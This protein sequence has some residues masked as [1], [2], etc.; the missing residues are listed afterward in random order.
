MI[1]TYEKAFAAMKLHKGDVIA[2]IGLTT[3]E[4]YAIKYS[5]TSLGL[6]LCNLNVLD[7]DIIDENKNRLFRQLENIKP[8]NNFYS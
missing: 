5:A 3:P 8:K 2:T 7:A 4:I 6:I 1:F